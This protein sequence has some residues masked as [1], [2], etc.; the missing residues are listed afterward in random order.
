MRGEHAA[1]VGGT[2][3]SVPAGATGNLD[4]QG[5][6]SLAFTSEKGSLRIPY[7][8]ITELEFGQKVGRR[9]GATIALGVTTL[10]LM[11]LP[12]LFSKK[13]KHFLT[14]SFIDGGADQVAV[15]ELAKD[16]VT[17]TLKVLEARSRKKISYTG[18][19]GEDDYAAKQKHSPSEAKANPPASTPA[20]SDNATST[21]SSTLASS[22]VAP[23]A[24]TL[25]ADPNS[26][27]S[28]TQRQP[29]TNAD[30]V[31]MAKAGLKQ[32]LIIE[33]IK[34]CEPHFSFISQSLA[35][36]QQAG[37]SDE[38]IKEMARRQNGL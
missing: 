8:N 23:V 29:L 37:V 19:P 5:K 18:A 11:A 4:V 9:V 16:T 14:V 6:E 28:T 31:A 33:Q 7:A 17:T 35:A 38:T 20:A 2:L 27:S 32:E 1:Y 22:T 34:L 21:T 12:M 24:Q 10:G 36:L 13:K 25:I 26:R 15:F 3:T 30:I